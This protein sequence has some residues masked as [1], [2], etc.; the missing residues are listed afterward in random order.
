MVNNGQKSDTLDIIGTTSC[1]IWISIRN[2]TLTI[3]ILRIGN[4]KQ[5]NEKF[6]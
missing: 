2:T 6:S 5:T 1:N 3:A 4:A